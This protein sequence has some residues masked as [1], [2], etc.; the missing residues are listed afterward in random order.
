[1]TD[2]HVKFTHLHTKMSEW[3]N[4]HGELKTSLDIRSDEFRVKNI[5]IGFLAVFI[6]TRSFRTFANY[7]IPVWV[8]C[9][10]DY[11]IKYIAKSLMDFYYLKVINCSAILQTQHQLWRKLLCY[12][13]NIC[14]WM[15][16]NFLSSLFLYIL[17]DCRYSPG[18]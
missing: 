8:W 12:V 11:I 15:R 17:L 13:K 6:S 2:S 16:I 7:Y 10:C 1:M 3:V 5:L 18:Y 14:N 9:Q 4:L